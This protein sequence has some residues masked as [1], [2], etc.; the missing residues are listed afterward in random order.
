ML[1]QT[2]DKPKAEKA[3]S[4]MGA[5]KRTG[6]GAYVGAGAY[7]GTGEWFQRVPHRTPLT[8]YLYLK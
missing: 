3:V 1:F 2:G 8:F 4:K 7:I 6:A 5:V